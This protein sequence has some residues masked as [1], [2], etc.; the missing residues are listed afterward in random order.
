MIKIFTSREI[1]LFFYVHRS[2]SNLAR[3]ILHYEVKTEKENSINLIALLHYPQLLMWLR[4]GELKQ[5]AFVE[6]QKAL[7]N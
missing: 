7:R 1:Q 2:Y 6:Y 5:K 4:A 3:C